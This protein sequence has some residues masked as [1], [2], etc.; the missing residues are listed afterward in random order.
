MLKPWRKRLSRLHATNQML[1]GDTCKFDLAT[2]RN[3]TFALRRAYS[4]P[5]GRPAAA[6]AVA[7]AL[8]KKSDGKVELQRL[9]QQRRQQL[10]RLEESIELRERELRR[11]FSVL[12]GRARIADD[13]LLQLLQAERR[14]LKR[15]ERGNSN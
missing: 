2:A 14:E 15:G 5:H 1:R 12:S 4:V 6:A 10:A 13:E 7:E 8:K 3:L 9:K 11:S